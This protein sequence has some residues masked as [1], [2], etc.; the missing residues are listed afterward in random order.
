MKK[1]LKKIIERFI[2]YLSNM[3][4]REIPNISDSN[5]FHSL[6]PTDDAENVD[7]YIQSIDWALKNKTKIKVICERN[8]KENGR[9][10]GK[11]KRTKRGEKFCCHEACQKGKGRELLFCLQFFFLYFSV[12]C[13][14]L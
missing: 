13:L 8:D 1:L 6:S 7:N 12:M 4:Q 2:R 5:F 11:R 14:S 9:E 3:Q 10:R